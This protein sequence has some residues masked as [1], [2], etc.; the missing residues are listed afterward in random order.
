[1]TTAWW[2]DVPG[3][4]VAMHSHDFPE[5]RWVLEGYLRVTADGENVDLGPGDRIDLPPNMPYAMEVMGLSQVIY[6]SG[7][8]RSQAAP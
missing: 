1:M 5:T 4:Q 6:V 2:S 3:A 8:P 7:K